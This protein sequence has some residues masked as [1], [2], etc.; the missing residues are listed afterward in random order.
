[1]I[2]F[3]PE[4]TIAGR[5]EQGEVPA[6]VRLG[7]GTLITGE[8]AFRRHRTGRDPALVVGRDC[9]LDEVQFSYGLDGYIEIGDLCV[10]SNTIFMVEQE[11]TVGNRVVIGWNTY[12]ADS[13]FHPLQPLGR[14][15]DTV[16]C[17]PNGAV[18]DL[19]RPP[20]KHAPVRID[21]DVW[22]GPACTVLKGVHV[23]AGAF[24]EPG[25]VVT[26]DVAPRARVMGNPARVIGRV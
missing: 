14:I 18:R 5:W 8:H 23:G 11:I 24:V 20:I 1:M 10:L 22:I 12:L 16:A 6:N 26:S 4:R 17:S 3:V 15:E 19:P 7:P 13:D 25:S 9:V 2:A 21:D